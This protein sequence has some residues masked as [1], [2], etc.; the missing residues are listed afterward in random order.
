MGTLFL[1]AMVDI[2]KNVPAKM[3]KK[4]QKYATYVEKSLSPA[5][6]LNAGALQ[7]KKAVSDNA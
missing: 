7:R 5:G 2:K 6:L 4:C 1:M 3:H